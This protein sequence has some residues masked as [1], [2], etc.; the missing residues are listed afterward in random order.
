M[1]NEKDLDIIL[2]T[3]GNKY[4]YVANLIL[5]QNIHAGNSW[6]THFSM[7]GGTTEEFEKKNKENHEKLTKWSDYK[8]LVPTLFLFYHGLE[9][10]MKGLITLKG[11]DF[12]MAH[13]LSN[14][15]SKI[16]KLYSS[17]RKLLDI[18]GKWTS[19]S[20]APQVLQGFIKDNKFKNINEM[21]L[22]LRYPMDRKQLKSCS[23]IELHYKEEEG[24]K[25][26][27]ELLEDSQSIMDL[28]AKIPKQLGRY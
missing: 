28:I 4:F 19:S 7:Q 14:L 20:K 26:A 13:D 10:T 24:K 5:E 25:F 16:A 21:Y 6:G 8:T 3:I 23:Y 22:F 12:K 1:E 18:I 2:L 15:Y 11:K 9:V 17:H 27:E